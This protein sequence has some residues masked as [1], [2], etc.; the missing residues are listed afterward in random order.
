MPATKQQ[1]NI[2][3]AIWRIVKLLFHFA[4]GAIR[5]LLFVRFY[6]EA[7]KARVLT[8]WS[9]KLMRLLDIR[10]VVEG[11]LPK[12]LDNTLIV[13][14]HISWLDILV[15]FTVIHPRFVAKKEIADWPVLG[16]FTKLGN[17]VFIERE[18][19]RSMLQVNQQLSALLAAGDYIAIFP[20]GGTSSGES[21]QKFKAGLF[22]PIYSAKGSVLPVALQ[23]LDGAGKINTRPAYIGDM[24]LLRSIWNVLSCAKLTIKVTFT[25]PLVTT[26]FA[27]RNQLAYA[28]QQQIN[29]HWIVNH[30]STR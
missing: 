2:F 12:R 3:I 20:E 9:Y 4:I 29:K 21:V 11:D 22:E 10:V 5:V 23:Y 18:N 28:A 7:K 8:A 24:S 17:T 19:K 26:Q 6:D 27:D 16:W 1:V 25:E 14:N 13:A 15:I 30:E